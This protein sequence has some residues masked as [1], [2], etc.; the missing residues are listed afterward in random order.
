MAKNFLNNAGLARYDEKIKAYIGAK[1]TEALELAKSYADGKDVEINNLKQL[2]GD[3]A[4]ATQINTAV[5]DAKTELKGSESDTDASATIAGAKKYADKLD[6]AMDARVDVLEAAVGAGGSV[7]TQIATEI[8]KLD[9]TVETAAIPEGQ[10]GIHVKVT[11]V[12]GKLTAVE[13]EIE[14]SNEINAAK[15]AL[16]NKIGTVTEGKTLAGMIADNAAAIEEHKTAVDAKVTTLIGSDADKSV[17]TIANEELAAQ[18]IPDNAAES[19]DTLQEIAN[20]IQNHPN[21][22]SAMN[23]AITALQAKTKLGQYIPEGQAEAVEY[24]TVE[25]YVEAI[26]KELATNATGL[27]SRVEANENAIATINGDSNTA[28]SIN[29]ALADAK[30]YTDSKTQSMTSEEIEAI[31]AAAKTPQS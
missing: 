1:D 11:E 7:S 3:T 4:V 13:A 18:L 28:G 12:D 30:V 16:E 6:A 29:K 17:R 8:Q 23:S 5:S 21:D 24:A 9:A 27:A 14:V 10:D 19:L 31:I 20:W 22:A 15:T 26:K 2:V 25:A